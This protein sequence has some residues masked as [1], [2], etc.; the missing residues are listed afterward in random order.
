MITDH[1]TVQREGYTVPLIGIPPAA[2]K[3]QCDGCRK[4]FALGLVSLVDGQ[5]LC[6]ECRRNEEERRVGR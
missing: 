5:I 1:A 6:P 2:V 4:E 3:E